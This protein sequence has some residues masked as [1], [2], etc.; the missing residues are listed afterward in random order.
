M[1]KKTDKRNFTFDAPCPRRSL[2]GWID[3][4]GGK[5][6]KTHNFWEM[7]DKVHS[8]RHFQGKWRR[9]LSRRHVVCCRVVWVWK[10]VIQ[11]VRSHIKYKLL[12]SLVLFMVNQ[13]LA[14][15]L[16]HSLHAV[17]SNIFTQNVYNKWFLKCLLIIKDVKSSNFLFN[18]L[19]LQL[20]KGFFLSLKDWIKIII[21]FLNS[22]F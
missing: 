8:A 21:I 16:N 18:L 17:K 13:F 5:G 10:V 14:L 9:T 3:Y 2:R 15:W 19:S 22:T 4:R 20:N 7:Y 1:P 12:A 6:W 11:K